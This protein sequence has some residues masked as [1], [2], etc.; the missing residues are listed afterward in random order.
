MSSRKKQRSRKETLDKISESTIFD[1]FDSS[2]D[3]FEESRDELD[4]QQ[5]L[6]SHLSHWDASI[7][8][9]V[10]SVDSLE[11]LIGEHKQ[12]ITRHLWR[13]LLLLWVI[14][15]FMVS[16]LL[17]LLQSNIIL[18]AIIQATALMAAA[19]FLGVTLRPR[20]QEGRRKWTH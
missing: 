12:V 15:G 16:G 9:D 19:I 17:L 13:D 20:K 10:P 1:K 18:F 6:G 3:S 11:Q 8:P 2:D 5:L 4:F 7:S 14:G